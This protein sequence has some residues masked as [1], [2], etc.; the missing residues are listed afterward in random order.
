MLARYIGKYLPG[1]PKV[2]VQ[3]VPGAGGV[4]LI[5]Q[6]Y[7]VA[8]KDGTLSAPSRPVRSSSR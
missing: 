2:Q 4:R 5:E 8:P 6:L 7:M 3:L 1:Q